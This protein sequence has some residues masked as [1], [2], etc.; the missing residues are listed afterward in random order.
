MEKPEVSVIIIS[1]NTAD[2]LRR[3]LRSLPAGLPGTPYEVWVVD[4]AS[5]D[6]SAEMVHA[7]FPAARLILN[8]ENLGFAKANN[9]ALRLMTGAYALLLNSD[10]ML[11]PGAGRALLDFM[12]ARPAAGMA[13]PLLLDG[14]GR[15]RPSTYPLPGFWNEL[16]KATKFYA[17]LP[18]GAAGRLLLGSFFDHKSAA[19]VGRLTGACVLVPKAVIDKVG[20]LCEDFF[21]YGEVHDWCWTMIER[22]L[23]IWFY[24]GAAAV[25]LGGQSS[26]KKWDSVRAL[27]VTLDAH[28]RMLGRHKQRWLIGLMYAAA[29]AGNAAALAYRAAFRPRRDETETARLRAE[30]RWYLSKLFRAPLPAGRD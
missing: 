22:G 27:L 17:L 18:A 8:T 30:T 1:Y 28:D 20:L 11:E 13:G 23:E 15:A 19:R 14:E 29:L 16:V 26:K 10:A 3:C 5:A 24:P 2:L 12:K 21:F 6:G 9:Q 25:H 7:E 4:N